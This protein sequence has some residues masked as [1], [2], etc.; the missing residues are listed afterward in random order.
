MTHARSRFLPGPVVTCGP[1]T[2]PSRSVSSPPEGTLDVC[3]REPTGPCP[4]NGP[5][6]SSG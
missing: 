4:L 3:L 6:F 1:R 5:P 2:V